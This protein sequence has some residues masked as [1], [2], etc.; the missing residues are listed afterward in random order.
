MPGAKS[1]FFLVRGEALPTVLQKTLEAKELLR[2]GECRTVREAVARVGISRSAFYK[3]RDGVESVDEADGVHIVALSMKLRHQTGVLSRV[4]GV[5]AEAKGSVRTINQS[6]PVSGVAPVTITFETEARGEALD[7]ILH[8]LRA[9][10]G[11]VQVELVG[12]GT[13]ISA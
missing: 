13:G 4:L 1:D 9:V 5:I 10:E 6:Q 7:K 8:D 11:V 2:R 3:Y 12:E